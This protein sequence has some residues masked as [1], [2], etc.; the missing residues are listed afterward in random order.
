VKQLTWIV[1]VSSWLIAPSPFLHC[2]AEKE[3]AYVDWHMVGVR[4]EL[5][6]LFR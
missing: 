1:S 2:S 5:E 6:E 4:K 3:T